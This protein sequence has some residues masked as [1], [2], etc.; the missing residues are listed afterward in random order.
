[1]HTKLKFILLH[2]LFISLSGNVALGNIIAKDDRFLFQKTSDELVLN[3][4]LNDEL[5]ETLDTSISIVVVPEI[6]AV[7][8][9]E[10]NNWLVFT[11]G[12][13]VPGIYT[14]D[15]EVCGESDICGFTCS[16]ATVTIEIIASPTL[17]GG[18]T[19]DGNNLN[20]SLT[21]RGIEGINRMDITIVNRWGDLVYEN[22]DYK[23]ED[24]WRGT[25][26]R[27]GTILPEGAYYYHL[28][29]YQ[30]EVLIGKPIQGVI[31]LFE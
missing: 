11:L 23:N 30:N 20:S 16:Q 29:T 1:M 25:I 3:V 5:P 8:V 21:I 12:D 2:F 22:R 28:R 31:H 7:T 9:N 24:P 18:L 14:F 4:L 15:Y 6:G 10:E 26:G 17:S 19:I 13:N 27:S